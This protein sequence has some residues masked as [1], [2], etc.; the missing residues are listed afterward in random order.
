MPLMIVSPLLIIF[1]DDD[2]YLLQMKMSLWSL[3][4]IFK[5]TRKWKEHFAEI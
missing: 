3:N 5:L 4:N 2:T 1:V